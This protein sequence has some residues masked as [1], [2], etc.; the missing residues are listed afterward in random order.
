MCVIRDRFLA[1]LEASYQQ[2]K[3]YSFVLHDELVSD[4]LEQIWK[5]SFLDYFEI[6]CH[7]LSLY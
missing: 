1:Y 2:L 5:K 3:F 7:N 4:E 6:P